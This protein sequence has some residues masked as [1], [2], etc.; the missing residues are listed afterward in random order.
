MGG[1][2]PNPNLERPTKPY[3]T[4][5]TLADALLGPAL[6]LSPSVPCQASRTV[7][8]TTVNNVDLFFA[9]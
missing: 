7:A 8:K 9:L 1:S 2:L 5:R 6:I 4:E 3:S